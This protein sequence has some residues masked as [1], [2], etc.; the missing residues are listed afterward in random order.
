MMELLSLLSLS[1]RILFMVE[2]SVCWL[3]EEICGAGI[4]AVHAVSLE[5]GRT[6]GGRAWLCLMLMTLQRESARTLNLL[7]SPFVPCCCP[8]SCPRPKNTSTRS[9]FLRCLIIVL[10]RSR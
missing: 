5:A 2:S 6:S 4:A 9:A 10:I 1:I 7:E 3:E 8:E